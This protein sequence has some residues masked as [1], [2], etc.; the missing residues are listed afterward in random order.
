MSKGKDSHGRSRPENANL[1]PVA[2]IRTNSVPTIFAYGGKN[3][4]V[5]STCEG[6]LLL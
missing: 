5:K 3:T 6:E 2:C 1:S 4:L